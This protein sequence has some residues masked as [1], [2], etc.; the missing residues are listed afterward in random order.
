MSG[1][2]GSSGAASVDADARFGELYER[3]HRSI[4]DY[5]RRRLEPQ[6]VDDAVSETFLTAWRRLDDLPDGDEALLWLY[7]VAYRVVGHQWRGSA[8]RRRLETRVRS[9]VRR[10]D[11]DVGDSIAARDDHQ[12]VL[13]AADTLGATDAEVLRLVAWEELSIAQIAD[14]LEIEPNAVKQR[15][16]RA[17][18]NLA[19]AYRRLDDSEPAAPDAPRGGAG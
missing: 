8:R 18:R 1:R 2:I 19:R 16:H 15:I 4:R 13:T 6:A 14:L 11:G 17:K 3:H 5:C 9:I 10:P 7:R 12:L